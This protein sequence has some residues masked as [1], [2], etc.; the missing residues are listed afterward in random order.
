MLP[1]TEHK[2]LIIIHSAG[3]YGFTMSSNYNT[4]G[5][6]AEVAIKDG[7]E[8]LIRERESFEDQIRLEKEFLKGDI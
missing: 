5:R 1:K 8:F 7:K 2:D 3:A 4:R 6:A